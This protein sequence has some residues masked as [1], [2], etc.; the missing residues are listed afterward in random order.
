M[1]QG[2][3]IIRPFLPAGRRMTL[4]VIAFLAGISFLAGAAAV[5]LESHSAAV[6]DLGDSAALL[7]TLG[8]LCG[9]LAGSLVLLQFVLSARLKSLDRIFGLHGL[10]VSHRVL[11][12]SAVIFASF[13]P[14]LIFAPKA[15]TMPALHIRIWPILVGVALLM[16]LW[17][18]V[19]IALWRKFLD[20]PYSCWYRMHCIGMFGATALLT[21]HVG[22]V[23]RDF[24]RGWPR[25]ALIAAVSMYAILFI[26]VILIKPWL[27]KKRKFKVE[28]VSFAGKNTYAIELKPKN[29]GTFSYAP[30]QFAF[31][32][33]Y[34]PLL[35][36]ERH[37]WT[38]SSA[39]TRPQTLT[40]TI[41]CSGDFTNRISHLKPGDEAVVDGPY[42]RFSY[43]AH[44]RDHQRELIMIAG[45]VGVT[46]M[47][48]M[49]GYMTD[50]GENKKVILIWSNKTE[51]DILYRK[52]LEAIWNDM[53]GLTI[54]QVLT[55]QKDFAGLTGRLDAV[56][57]KGILTGWDRNGE[58]FVCGPPPMMAAVCRGLK[59]IGFKARRIHSEKFSY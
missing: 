34:S 48:S 46:P 51:D 16:G 45:G 21:I 40:F 41:K 50:I 49:L 14:M 20:L 35:P 24:F 27:G 3:K 11:G 17:A 54:R 56:M 26:V 19:S 6:I 10:F 43:P 38:I 32:T 57:L 53:E 44:V 23:A 2:Q 42:G 52:E 15:V 47:L 13:H 31:V 39:P 12:V 1:K 22:N 59:Q 28:R 55:R 7:V 58:V 29:G 18:G 30:G 33:F 8:K 4:A 36:V 5:A 9:L 25:Y 37:P